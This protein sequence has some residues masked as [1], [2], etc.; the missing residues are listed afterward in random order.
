MEPNSSGRNKTANKQNKSYRTLKQSS[1]KAA[2]RQEAHTD[3][4]TLST[5]IRK[6]KKETKAQKEKMVTVVYKAEADNKRFS[7]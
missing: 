7:A 6:E 4:H 2:D 5:F 1:T 3:T